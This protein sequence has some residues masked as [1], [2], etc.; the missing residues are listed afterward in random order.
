MAYNPYF[1][2]QPQYVQQQSSILWV[3][4][5]VEAMSYPVAPNNAVALWDST[6]PIVYVKQADASGR[7]SMKAY[8]LVERTE[9]AQNNADTGGN[10]NTADYLLKS[11][12]DGVLSEIAAIKADLKKV[13]RELKRRDIDD[14]E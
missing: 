2:Y 11:E 1:P 10:I 13:Q 12:F 5:E 6:K 8:N 9:T 7:P 4:S 14:D 3:T